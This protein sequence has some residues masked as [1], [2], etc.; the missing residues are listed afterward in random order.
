MSI[1]VIMQEKTLPFAQREN[2]VVL[3][4][5]VHEPHTRKPS[6]NSV[7]IFHITALA[8]DERVDEPLRFQRTRLRCLRFRLR[9]GQHPLVNHPTALRHQNELDL[10]L[11]HSAPQPARAP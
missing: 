5:G 7:A 10:V 9:C 2:S 3:A 1:T 4:C 8:V 11:V 6:P